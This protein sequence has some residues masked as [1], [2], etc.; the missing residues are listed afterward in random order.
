MSIES[1][2]DGDEFMVDELHEI[3]K[4]ETTVEDA[5]WNSVQDDD[6]EHALEVYETAKTNLESIEPM[7]DEIERERM[8]VLSYCL[9]RIND[10]LDR[11]ERLEDSVDRAEEVL[12][13][14]LSSEDQVQILRA[15]MAL[16]VAL[17]NQG[18]LVEAESHFTEIIKQTQDETEDKDMIQVYGWTLIVRVNILIGKSLYGQARELANQALDVL[19]GIE[20]YAGLRTAYSLLSQLY[21]IEGDSEKS[22]LYRQK[23]EDYAVL[24]K[25][26]RQ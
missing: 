8:R 19:G 4:I 2:R 21:Q 13:I 1:A 11:L 14:A 5:M 12:R 6:Y 10:A 20:N 15:K 3:H 24:A 23:S 18:R 9:M 7:N 25:E 16:G 22:D 26:H 17:L